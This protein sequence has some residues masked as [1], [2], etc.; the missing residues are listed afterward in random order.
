[1]VLI[2]HLMCSLPDPYVALLH[3]LQGHVHVVLRKI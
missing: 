3:H 1:M 2:T